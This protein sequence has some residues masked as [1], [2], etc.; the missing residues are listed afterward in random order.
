MPVSSPKPDNRPAVDEWG[1]YDPDQAGFSALLDRI[2]MKSRAIAERDASA[3]A[4][5][6][7]DANQLAKKPAK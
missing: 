1:V 5:S 6:M 3:M 4:A 2:A 7:R